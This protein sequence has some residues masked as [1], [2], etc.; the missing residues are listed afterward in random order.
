[1]SFNIQEPRQIISSATQTL[2]FDDN[3]LHITDALKQLHS[4]F[5]KSTGVKAGDI[6]DDDIML[7]TG[8]AIS[9]IKAAHCLMEIERTRRFLKGIF[10]AITQLLEQK[11]D[12]PVTILYA[13]CGP[14]ATLLTP[15]TS[16]FTSE[17]VKFIFLDINP[18]SLEAAKQLYNDLQLQDYVID[19]VCTDAT[20]YQ[21]QE[22]IDLFLSETM[23]N[24]LRR[25]PQLAIMDNIIPQLDPDAIV[26]PAEITINAVLTRW[27]EER[28]GF[29]NENYVPARIHAG[30]V[31][32][33]SREFELPKPVTI[34]VPASKTHNH[35]NLFTEIRVFD[36]EMLHP[37]STSLTIPISINGF[38]NSNKD[39]DVSF[40]YVI[41]E[42][43]EFK[44]SF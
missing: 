5:A 22:N 11:K 21:V 14:Y 17:Q 16:M 34:N 4:V 30:T 25:E 32:K 15:L 42:D 31:Y 39:V 33:T 40:N 13:G 2:L 1:M 36:N 41:S 37:Y 27:E 38:D 6:N 20:T 19:F 23:L 10:K 24:G 35:L 29:F 18:F 3:Y 43:P 8:K 12:V 9:T 26:I 44:V 28:N 7:P